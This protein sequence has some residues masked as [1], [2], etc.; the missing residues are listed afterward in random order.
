[1]E[2]ICKNCGEKYYA[3]NL[4]NKCYMKL[5]NQKYYIKHKDIEL[6][7]A[8]I[9]AS[10][11]KDRKKELEILNRTEYN[12]QRKLHEKI[13]EKED[14]SFRLLNILRARVQTAIREQYTNKAL[15]TI[16]LLGCSI[17]K[18][19]QHIEKQFKPGMSWNNYKQWQLHHIK[20]C[21]DF[22]LTKEEEQKKCFHYTN[23]QPL[24]VKEHID[25]HNKLSKG[26]NSSKQQYIKKVKKV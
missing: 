6:P 16:K 18:C 7:R 3:F 15:T 19:R 8:R 17:Q 4:C 5:Y 26:L 23:L 21:I 2:K 13:R 25:L 11:H 24:W 1:M 9:Y 20:P 22:D 14:I 12:K 10:L